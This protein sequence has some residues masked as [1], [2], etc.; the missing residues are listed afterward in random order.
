MRENHQN[1]VALPHLQYNLIHK[2]KFVADV[3]NRI[4]DLIN[5]IS[6]CLFKKRAY[7]SKQ[8]LKTQKK[9]KE[10]KNIY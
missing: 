2:I 1:F 10:L 7:L 6:K 8:P 3:T 5:F 4:Y 9:L